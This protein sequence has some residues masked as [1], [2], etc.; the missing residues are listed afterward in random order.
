MHLYLIEFIFYYYDGDCS[1][2]CCLVPQISGGLKKEN[3][4]FELFHQSLGLI[5][6]TT[7]FLERKNFLDF[8]FFWCLE[9]NEQL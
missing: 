8:T 1:F 5:E 3:W 9:F 7:P 2:R 4:N 6:S